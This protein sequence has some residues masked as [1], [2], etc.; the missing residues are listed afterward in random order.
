MF[1][2]LADLKSRL[3]DFFRVSSGR[4]SNNFLVALVAL[5]AVFA[6]DEVLNGL[7]K[8]H[9]VKEPL[10]MVY[11]FGFFL[12]LSFC[13]MWAMYLFLV[14]FLMMEIVQINFMV[15]FGH[16]ITASEIV[17]IVSERADV[18]DAAYLGQTWFVMPLL[19]LFYGL[20]CFVFYVWGKD[21]IK[22]KWLLLVV[23]YLAAHKPY[24]AYTETKGI[25]Y[26]QPGPTRSTLK[27]SI[28]TFSY[29][30]FQ[31]LWK[32]TQ[33]I[34]V[35]YA[36]Y[37][38]MNIPADKKNILLIWGESLY[39]KHLP[40]FG[41]QRDTFPRMQQRIRKGGKIQTTEV[42]SP[43]ISTA[44]STP[45]FFNVVREP[46]NLKEVYAKTANLFRAAKQNGFETYYISNQESRLL[47]NLG[48][49]YID[50][51]INND[52]APLVFGRY[53]DEG[54][55]HFLKDID[56][57]DGK[58]FVVLHMRTPHLPY[59]KHYQ[60]HKEN[61]EK[62]LP[63]SEN[64][65]RLQ[66]Y[67]NTYDNALLYADYVID[68]LISDFT[69]RADMKES[70]VFVTADHGQL[71]DYNGMWGHNNLVPE[72]V[73][74]PGIVIG[75]FSFILPDKM[76]G[77]QFGKLILESLG[78]SLINENEKADTYYIHGNNIEFPYDYIEYKFDRD[79]GIMAEGVKNTADLR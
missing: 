31:Y 62:F 34:Q 5:I 26:F 28:N 35:N 63:V 6:P 53:H 29:F 11:V 71:F 65:G 25:W 66:Y 44:T 20:T 69:K 23:L 9:I 8:A 27:N 68:D 50:H 2:Y 13:S 41:Y 38:I 36:P 46:A 33:A 77:Y 18:F 49:E 12:L 21:A 40:M 61:F 76:S 7:G 19:I 56:L 47:M 32:D 45:L 43:G 79:R 48:D 70:A 16:P 24:R 72:Q 75:D 22:A 51:I 15:F 59:E 74:V 1:V 67:T 14:L 78:S 60:N 73:M 30:F 10:F 52:S 37:R 54:L 42:L 57:Q 58:H 3:K 64:A 4:F 55:L 17:N 39:S